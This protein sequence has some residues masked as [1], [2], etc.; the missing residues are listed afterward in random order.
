M[1]AGNIPITVIVNMSVSTSFE[2]KKF[3]EC[4]CT[5]WTYIV[6]HVCASCVTRR[7]ECHTICRTNHQRIG[8]LAPT[9]APWHCHGAKRSRNKDMLALAV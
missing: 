8:V 3:F 5:P 2:G 9:G 4:R 7:E 6:C 1:L